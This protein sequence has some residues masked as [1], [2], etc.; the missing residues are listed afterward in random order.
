M[1]QFEEEVSTTPTS[2]MHGIINGNGMK[3][4]I[5]LARGIGSWSGSIACHYIVM[6]TQPS[7][8][9]MVIK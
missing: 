6:E 4:Q 7:F 9:D 1:D 8:L 5:L 2:I 3:H